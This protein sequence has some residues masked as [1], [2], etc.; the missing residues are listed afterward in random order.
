MDKLL[1][2]D[3][4][5][6]RDALRRWKL[7]DTEPYVL[8]ARPNPALIAQAGEERDARVQ[9][10]TARLVKKYGAANEQEALRRYQADYDKGTAEIDAA[11]ARLALPRFIDNPPLGLDEQLDYKVTRLLG[12]I[13]LLAA[14]FE[15]MTGAHAG[16]ALRLGGVPERQL[17]YL[18]ALPQLLTRMGV[19]CS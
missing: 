2:G 16:L 17:I 18:S 14:T 3:R 12:G 19:I 6:W 15:S 8:G 11:A 9:A 4:N 10:E 1:A 5:L 13:P 7:V